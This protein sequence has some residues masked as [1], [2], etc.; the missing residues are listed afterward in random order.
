MSRTGLHPQ[1]VYWASS[2]YAAAKRQE[3]KATKV[4]T[5]TSEYGTLPETNEIPL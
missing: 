3:C 4:I 2:R 5:T 1:L